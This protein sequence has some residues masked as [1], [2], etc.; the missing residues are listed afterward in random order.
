MGGTPSNRNLILVKKSI[1]CGASELDNKELSK[2]AEFRHIGLDEQ[3]ELSQHSQ[4]SQ[5]IKP[6]IIKIEQ[7]IADV[8]TL[9]SKKFCMYGYLLVKFSNTV[10]LIIHFSNAPE[11]LVS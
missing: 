10:I 3:A 1:S 8:T 2:F 9:F 6:S 11:F 5:S 7:V 4:S